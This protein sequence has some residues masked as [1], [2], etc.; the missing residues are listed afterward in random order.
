[1]KPGQLAGLL[2]VDAD[3]PVRMGDDRRAIVDGDGL[4]GTTSGSLAAEGDGQRDGADP[5]AAAKAAIAAAAAD[6][7]DD[8]AGRIRAVRDN[9]LRRAL[10]RAQRD[11]I[12]IA[13][14]EDVVDVPHIVHLGQLLPQLRLGHVGPP[15]VEHINHLSQGGTGF[16]I[17][18]GALGCTA[19][20]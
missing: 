17:P 16:M 11:G 6:R 3:R 18:L 8:Q 13:E 15:R 14:D 2:R 20:M 4:G 19:S 10:G 5:A 7:L 9:R 12:G 1:M